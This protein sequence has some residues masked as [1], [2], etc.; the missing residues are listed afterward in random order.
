MFQTEDEQ[1]GRT[2]CL[3]EAKV[4]R[5]DRRRRRRRGDHS[6]TE[7]LYYFQVASMRCACAH[8]W[9][10]AVR[11]GEG[12]RKKKKEREERKTS[13]FVTC[14]LAQPT[15]TDGLKAERDC[16]DGGRRGGE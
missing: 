7:D 14:S 5:M 3:V 16:A 8:G 11:L 13:R 1:G 6:R 10:E 12:S 9:P 4:K 2:E 15:H